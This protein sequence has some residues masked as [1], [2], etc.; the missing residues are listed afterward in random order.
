MVKRLLF[1]TVGILF[2]QISEAFSQISI[3]TVDPGPYTPESSIAAT[4]SLGPD[5]IKPGNRFNLYLVSPGGTEELI[6]FY[7]SF[8]STFVN[9]RIPPS[10]SPGAGYV[11][12]IKSTNPVH[13]SN[14][15][16]PFDIVGGG[17]ITASLSSSAINSAN[18]ETFGFCFNKET[19]NQLYISNESTAGG[20]VTASITNELTGGTPVQLTFGASPEIFTPGAA[21][22]TMFAKVKMPNGSTATKAYFIINNKTNTAFSTSGAGVV[23]LPEGT[24]KYGVFTETDNGV[25]LNFP[26]NIYKIVWGDG[27]TDIYTLCDLKKG[28][29]EHKYTTSSCGRDYNNG[30]NIFYNV[31]GINISAESPFCGLIGNPLST[32]AKVID[33]T[34]NKFSGPQNGCANTPYTFYNES[35]AGQNPS[36]TDPECQDNNVK[37]NWYI[38]GAIFK[39]N[40]PKSYNLQFPPSPSGV[41]EIK[42]VS[43]SSGICQDAPF[44]Q[45]ICIQN[46]PEPAFEFNGMTASHCAPFSV[47]VTDKSVIDARC[48]SNNS[49]M[50]MVTRN[51]IAANSSEVTFTNGITEPEFTFH[52]QGTYQVSL[53]INTAT[54]GPVS[55]TS[56]TVVIID[57]KP[58]TVL[59]PVAI[60]CGLGTFTYNNQPG[61]TNVQF[62][63]TEVDAA[64]TYTWN[65]TA[66][67]DSALPSTDYS[68]TNGTNVTKYPSIR[69]N[70]YRT[71]KVSVTHKNSCNEFT[72]HQL[73]TF[74]ESPTPSIIANPVCYNDQANITGDISNTNYIS[75]TWSTPAGGGSFINDNTLEPTYTPSAADRL[76]GKAIVILTVN[77]GLADECKF[78]STTK[79]IIIHPNNTGTNTTQTICTGSLASRIL[80]SDVDG[81]T[82]TWTATNADG[83]ATGFSPIG[84]GDINE[85][86]T[87]NSATQH[88]VIVYTITPKANG[89]LGVPFTFTVTVTPKPIINALELNKTICDGQPVAIK[90]TSNIPTRFIWTSVPSAGISGNTNPITKTAAL[91]EL[92][93][94]D[95]LTNSTF[96]P[97][98]VTYTIKSYSD[99]DTEC[100]GNEIIVIVTVDPKVTPA[101]AGPDADICELLSYKLDGNIPSVGTG[102][103]TL[104][105]AQAGV[106][107]VNDTD[108]KTIVDNLT[109][110]QAYTFRW[111]ISAPGACE[112]SFKEVTVR[113]NMPTDPGIAATTTPTTVCAALNTG[114]ITLTGN[115]GNV[116]RW[117]SSTDNG[118]NWTQI[119]NATT[120]LTYSNIT[121]STQY[122]AV[123]KNGDCNARESNAILITVIPATTLATVGPDQFL[124]DATYTTI[125]GSTPLNGDTG[126]WTLE[127]GNPNAT[128]TNAT[129]PTTTVT[130]LVSGGTPYVF[131]WT[132]TGQSPCGEESA[133]LTVTNY[134]PLTNT[135]NTTS[136]EVCNGMQI[137]ITGAQPTGGNG[138]YTYTWES[139]VDGTNWTLIG[140]ETGPN[141]TYSLTT[142]LSFRRNVLSNQCPLAS[143]IVRIVAQPPITGNTISG[144]QT[145]C[146]GKIPAILTGT[147][148]SGSNGDFSFQWQRSIDGT[149]WTDIVAA[150]QADYAPGI[151][152]APTSF[153]RLVRTSAC[154]GTL[155]NISNV[156]LISTKPN[157]I[158]KILFTTDKS[159]A[160]FLIDF[161]NVRAEAHPANN[162][163]YIWKVN[164]VEVGRGINF[165]SYTIQNS[166]ESVIIKLI[167]ISA[168][169]CENDED[170]HTFST[171]QSVPASFNPTTTAD[172]GPL[173]V[174]FV[175]TSLQ[176]AGA[177]FRWNF[178]NGQ[179]S[180]DTNPQPV[181]FLAEASG[182]DTTYTVTLYSITSCGTDS[183][184]A[185]VFVKAD[186][187]SVFSPS[188]V[189]G[190]SPLRID[191][192]NTSPGG[193]NTYYY[194]FGDGT[195]LTKNDKSPV[196]HIYNVTVTT[197]FI[198]R[199]IADNGCGR[200]ESQ[201]TIRVSP[202][203][204]TPEL[205]VKVEETEGCAPWTVNFYNNSIGASRFTYDFGDGS[206]IFPAPNTNT[207]QH[208]YT[209]P[210]TFTITMTAYNSCSEI[211]TTETVTVL[212]QPLT[213]FEADNILG[214]PGL[215]VKFKNNTQNGFSYAWDFGD[216]STSNEF[217]PTHTYTGDQEYYTV[218]LT[219]TNTLGCTMTVTKNQY[220]HIV[221]PPVAAFKVNPSTLINIPDYTFKFEDQSTNTPTIWEWDFGDGTGSALKNPSHT[222]LD[223]GTYKVTLK[224]LNQQGCFTSTFKNVTIKGVP[225][226]L[227][228]PNS[229]VP[230]N[231]QPE[232]REFRAKGSGIAT[233]R[234]SIFNKWGQLLWESTKLEEGRPVE[235]WD[236]TFKGQQLP[237]GVYFWKVDVQMV[238]GSEWKGMTYDSSAPK[239]T[240]AIHL[241]R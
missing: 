90:V 233:W 16:N 168:T 117:E 197:D 200:H 163:E 22:Y 152:N 7:D 205:V 195:T 240:G 153:R 130:N 149:N 215:M 150:T 126:L 239:R 75:Y 94:P 214:C 176:T 61:L 193:T 147:A 19:D 86:I 172:C 104:V 186:P 100:P 93:I 226:Y 225:G 151:L 47:T 173:T 160:P 158:A 2:F 44:I 134:R 169:A 31:F 69:F 170:T 95:A 39:A 84:S 81:S 128:I 18:P 219:A 88:A 11:L 1:L 191:F 115:I 216:G 108:P 58:K 224:V 82:F 194:D 25:Q 138:A 157:A 30:S 220:V 141:L 67:D 92:T 199:M 162:S 148:P 201:W 68:F 139:S 143:N 49:Y 192:T 3:G 96:S 212:P 110:G 14:D 105:S 5:C 161:H 4:F 51:G 55:T 77:T 218:T 119:V 60:Y 223:T 202:Q 133:R 228:V 171:N 183:A 211:S 185:T 29:V 15:S 159:C 221:Q 40:Q 71:Y 38:N 181:T 236:G 203:N 206:P 46:L 234:F 80:S 109:P 222:Y 45:T 10:A 59:A 106:H 129:S 113:V 235:G 182:K 196:F 83:N 26:G 72:T 123:V 70:Q 36:A 122:R 127:S 116:I 174:N 33:V 57:S 43:V 227:F 208:I 137:L 112:E 232:L 41:Y 52:K 175:N 154:N 184:K 167:T 78:V 165:P 180:N 27:S 237:Q 189:S 23:C 132:I 135:I 13:V 217:E 136:V 28:F 63:G 164:D 131:K 9:G 24:L 76:A 155:A 20:T 17:P 140:D 198:V 118:T 121:A 204:I 34:E 190:C 89:C 21:H 98:T 120:T 99:S 178:G 187:K 145:I 124:C 166:N 188:K 209:T 79:E 62:S 42:L 103:W 156:I 114:T 85:A 213:E 53:Q 54:C 74:K 65:V 238:N 56:Q 50:W 101:N 146:E 37:Y 179:T 35:V 64:D 142:T 241:I 32:Y 48:N 207:V 73:V 87:N 231:T 111:T 210:G 125:T 107:F 102:K 230:G 91:N 144:D 6:G 66:E 229:F 12:R 97:G 8:Y 177:T